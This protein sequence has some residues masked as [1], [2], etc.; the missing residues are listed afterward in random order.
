M[1][2]VRH[3]LQTIILICCLIE[4]VVQVRHRLQTIIL[5]CCLIEVVQVR[6]TLLFAIM[7]S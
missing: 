6:H 2:Q 4:R 5:I 7:L 1:V 3:R